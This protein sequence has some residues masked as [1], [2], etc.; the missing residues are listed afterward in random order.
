MARQSSEL[1]ARSGFLPFG[2]AEMMFNNQTNDPA[3]RQFV[4]ANN[5]LVNVYARAISPYGVPTVSD[6]EHAREMLSTAYDN[7][8]Y[9]AVLDQIQKRN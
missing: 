8:S 4:A 6:K 9:N 3:M 1:V 5:S 2:K 7:K